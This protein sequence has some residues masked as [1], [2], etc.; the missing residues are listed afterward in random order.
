MFQDLNNI[1]FIFYE[2]DNENNKSKGLLYNNSNNNSSNNIKN[3]TNSNYTNNVT[4][5]VFIK[6]NKKKT[7]KI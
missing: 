7:R 1:F 4:K 6:T 5:R 2:K 3:N